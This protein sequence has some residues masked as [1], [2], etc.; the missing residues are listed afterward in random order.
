[1]L[2]FRENAYLSIYREA[3]RYTERERE[4]EKE[5]EREREIYIYIYRERERDRKKLRQKDQKI[6]VGVKVFCCQ[7][8]EPEA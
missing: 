4:T 7:L 1:M 3:E 8:I 5:R 6:Y 2:L